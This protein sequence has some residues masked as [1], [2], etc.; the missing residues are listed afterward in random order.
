MKRLI[1]AVTF[2][3][4]ALC[5]TA[6]WA[7]AALEGGWRISS[8]NVEVRVQPNGA[9]EVAETITADFAWPKH[10][11]Y[12]RIPIHYDVALH[13]YS[14]RFRLLNVTDGAGRQRQIK[15]SH[16]HNYVRI[17]I[18]DPNRRVQGRQVYRIRYLV[19]RAI[20]FEGYQAVLRWN[21]TGNEWG[22]PI[23][24]TSVIVWLPRSMEEMEVGFDAW[25]GPYG[26]RGKD[27]TAS[28]VDNKTI[29]FTTGAFRPGEGIS[30]E[31][32]M[33]ASAVSR[34]TFLQRLG[35]GL[36]DNFA[37]GVF[38][39]VLV[40]CIGYWY[41]KGRDVPGRG[42]IVVQY[43]PPDDLGP[44]E[45][46][47]L[48]DERV[49]MHDISAVI[50]DFAVRGLIEIQEITEKKL[51]RFT[52][53]DYRFIKKG[54]ASGLKLH[55]KEI[56][57][58]LFEDGER[59]LL[60]ELK[61]NFYSVIPVV[62][63][64]IYRNLIKGG[65][66]DGSPKTVR[67]KF[68]TVGLALLAAIMVAAAILQN[69]LVGRLFLAPLVISSALSI[70]VVLVTSRVMPRKT[71][72]GSIAWEQ[73]SGLEEYIRRA[74][75][76]EIEDQERQGIFERLLPYAIVLGLADRWADA[77]EGIYSAPPNWYRTSGD[78]SKF[79]T[80]LLVYSIN[81]SVGSM[82]S[83]LPAAPRSSGTGGGGFG[84]GGWSGGGFSGGGFSGG[85]F[86]GGGGGGW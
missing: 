9:V 77:F 3:L 68:S 38:L 17:R 85:G 52:N 15:V 20:L 65:Y 67:R 18:G 58:K 66:F 34:P 56:F 46:G 71:R 36:G 2:L 84:G 1:I 29:M 60:S 86:G 19:Q 37:Y 6:S 83:T 22:V 54:E 75:A 30:V 61:H 24:E 10:G 72:K 23:D 31:I 33:P 78:P 5:L 13:Q 63:K 82:N 39:L 64:Q 28:R 74:E 11:I 49:N 40:G 45:V 41:K 73:I 57:D 81:G 76:R 12:R 79:S 62:K 16:E 8:F 44:A 80:N 27:F 55:E 21:A 51:L 43:E 69:A 50:I 47:T 35:W 25:T 42:S 48:A 53:T 14:L 7:G 59:V 26:A 32:G 4:A 70:A